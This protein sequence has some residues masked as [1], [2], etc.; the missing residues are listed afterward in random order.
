MA[1]N[2]STLFKAVG[3]FIGKSAEIGSHINTAFD[4]LGVLRGHEPSSTNATVRGMSGIFGYGDERAFEVLLET[5]EK[6][7]PGSREVLAGFFHWHFTTNTKEERLL[8][9]WYGN[10]FRS[11]VTKMG[12]VGT[13]EVIVETKGKKPD[14][15]VKT[16]TKKE[17][18]GTENNNALNFLNMMVK[19]I[20]DERD[21]PKGTLTKGYKKLIGRFEAFGVPHIPSGAVGTT[22]TLEKKLGDILGTEYCRTQSALLNYASEL[23]EDVSKRTKPAKNIFGR[24][25]TWNFKPSERK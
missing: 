14:E 24:I 2:P 11:F 18:K 8:S 16:V 6:D 7:T 25:S 10:A 23:E 15:T 20:R 13:E 4:F 3:T 19:T 22:K 12:V 1:L 17:L 5:L 9:W 21:A